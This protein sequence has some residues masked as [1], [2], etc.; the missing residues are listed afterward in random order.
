MD[1]L[2][3]SQ[4]SLLTY[5]TPTSKQG[6]MRKLV[7]LVGLTALVACA[8][9]NTTTPAA[10]ARSDTRLV[11][12]WELVSTRITNGATTLV[13]GAAPEIRA[14]KILNATDYSVVTRRGEQFVRAG[15]GRYTLT[16]N[17]YT[18]TVDLAS[19]ANFTPGRVYTF[20]IV[21]DGDTWTLDGGSDT[22]RLREV[23]RR[24]R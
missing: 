17:T 6:T 23:W 22:Q 2:I 8:S 9:S 18:E 4:R 3:F 11:G 5:V 19:G 1:F 15:T 21:I 10:S 13:E 12:T 7:T 14:L 20:Q 16:G 24:V